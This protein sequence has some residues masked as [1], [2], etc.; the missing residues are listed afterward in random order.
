MNDLT[1]I[2]RSEVAKSIRAFVKKAGETRVGILLEGET[3]TGKDLVAEATYWEGRQGKF[4][5]IDCRLV[6]DN[7]FE[8]ELFGHEAGAFT[9]AMRKK[10]GL[11]EV[12]DRGTLFFNE[13][14]NLLPEI[15]AK[16][17]RILDQKP[18]RAVGSVVEHEYSVRIIAATNIDLDKTM[19]AGTFRD[20]LY[21]RLR[22]VRYRIPP[23]RSRREDIPDLV[24]Y[25]LA[26]E[27]ATMPFSPEAMAMLMDH[28]WPGNVRDLKDTVSALIFYLPADRER[29]EECDVEAHLMHEGHHGPKSIP[30]DETIRPW[31]QFRREAQ[32]SYL[33]KLLVEAGG[34]V[35]IASE[36]SGISS[37]R[38]YTW[39]DSL[40]L[41]EFHK[42]TKLDL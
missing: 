1:I 33:K 25:F 13:V 20:D 7:M 28:H 19:E 16:F 32:I 29:V 41:K 26:R 3:G 17:L 30:P 22:K 12:A 15:Q 4:V 10:K 39:I 23:L 8:S 2:G 34:N 21:Y 5:P 24:K 36:I 27:N 18:V 9:S 11:L 14:G 31:R 6:N 42:S 40:G 35:N 37:K 38:M